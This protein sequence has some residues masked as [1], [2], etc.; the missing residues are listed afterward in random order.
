VT[1]TNIHV[2][3]VLDEAIEVAEF[4]EVANVSIQ[5]KVLFGDVV[6]QRLHFDRLILRRL[7]NRLCCRC[8]NLAGCPLLRVLSRLVS[9]DEDRAVEP[10]TVDDVVRELENGCSSRDKTCLRQ[11]RKRSVC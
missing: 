7:R 8:E 10:R 1:V 9:D 6:D 4:K 11:C 5:S 3:E 2:R